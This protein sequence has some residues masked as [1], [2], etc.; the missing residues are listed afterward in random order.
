MAIDKRR[1]E[2]IT[3]LR[4]ELAEVI[5][6]CERGELTT[7]QLAAAAEKL[8]TQG[9]ID[10]LGDEL[11]QH[12]YWAMKHALHR[13]AC[14]APSAEEIAYLRR[15]LRDEDLFDPAQVTSRL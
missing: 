10:V 1:E 15:C 2:R 14:W 6:C 5:E 8:I 7:R 13:P 3:W 12:T 4:Y 11:L 9:E